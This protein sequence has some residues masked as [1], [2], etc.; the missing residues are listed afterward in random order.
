MANKAWRDFLVH[1]AI[2]LFLAIFLRSFIFSVYRIPSSAMLP[3][4]MPGDFIWAIKYPYGVEIFDKKIGQ[5]KNPQVGS[6]YVFRYKQ[7][8]ETL[9]VKRVVA[10]AGDIVEIKNGV[11]MLNSVSTRMSEDCQ[12][13]S[14]FTGHEFFQC[15]QEKIHNKVYQIILNKKSEAENFGPYKV[16]ANHVFVLGDNRDVSDDSRFWGSIA[17]EEIVARADYIWLSIAASDQN[18]SSEK[19]FIRWERI[20]LKL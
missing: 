8:A 9:Y 12:T 1:F 2:A 15:Y 11:L 19:T 20:F 18:K 3:S 4:L 5:W 17:T 7:R 14:N 13:P 10:K 6:L 16:P